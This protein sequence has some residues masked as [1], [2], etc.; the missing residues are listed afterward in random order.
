MFYTYSTPQ[1]GL[2]LFQVLSSH[3]WLVVTIVDSQV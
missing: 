2:A 1:F 3:V